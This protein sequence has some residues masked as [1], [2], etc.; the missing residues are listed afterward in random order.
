MFENDANRCLENPSHTDRQII[1]LFTTLQKNISQEER[2]TQRAFRCSE[3]E[4][5]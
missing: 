4:Q 5:N 1:I 2:C 3:T